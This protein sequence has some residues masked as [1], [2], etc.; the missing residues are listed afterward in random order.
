M[1]QSL[2]NNLNKTAASL[3]HDSH[4]Y[5]ENPAKDNKQTKSQQMI[6]KEVATNLPRHAPDHSKQGTALGRN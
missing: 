2:S 4:A 3:T 5:G 6:K 1:L